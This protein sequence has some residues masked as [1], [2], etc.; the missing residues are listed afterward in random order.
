MDPITV[1]MG[2]AQFA[3]AIIKWITG[4]DKAED[5]AA[6]V[7]DIAK[8]VTGKDSPEDALNTMALDPA[9][10]MQFRLAV[11]QNESEMDRLYLAD[12]QNARERDIKL[13]QAGITNVRA[14]VLAAI[15]LGLVIV[16]LFIVVLESDLNEYAKGT[17]SLI[18]GRALGWVEQLFSFEYGTTRTSKTKDDTISRLSK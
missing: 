13:A 8:I 16:C 12:T 14:N 3:P 5:A 18:L 11:M 10:Q 6:K 1:A 9:A 7:V 15:A 2:L 17:L 4:S